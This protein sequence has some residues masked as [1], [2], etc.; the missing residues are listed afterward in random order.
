MAGTGGQ[1]GKPAWW[2]TRALPRMGPSVPL[3]RPPVP[4]QRP[5]MISERI[6]AAVSCGVQGSKPTPRA[7]SGRLRLGP[8]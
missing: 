2:E 6:K 8:A 7:Q 3:S 1:P 5:V 4:P